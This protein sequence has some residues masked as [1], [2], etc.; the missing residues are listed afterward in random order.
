MKCEVTDAM[1][2]VTQEIT[3]GGGSV[4]HE[5][6]DS[7]RNITHKFRVPTGECYTKSEM[8][9]EVLRRSHRLHGECD[10]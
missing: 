5:I 3:D 7:L 9:H 8:S 4:T 1:G 2:S 6:T 10:T